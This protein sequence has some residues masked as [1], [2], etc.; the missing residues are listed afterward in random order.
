MSIALTVAY[1]SPGIR[2][3]VRIVGPRP[4][5]RLRVGRRLVTVEDLPD[6]LRNVGSPDR[7]LLDGRGRRDVAAADARDL[8]DLD[9]DAVAV[10]LVNLRDLLVGAM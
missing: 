9:L 5:R 3:G 1:R 4:R 8:A 7:P 6:G 10:A 2:V